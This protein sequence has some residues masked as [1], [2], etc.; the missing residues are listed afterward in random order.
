M[1]SDV[2]RPPQIGTQTPSIDHVEATV[3]NQN[4][5]DLD[6]LWGLVILQ[7]ARQ[8]PG[9]GQGTS[10][11]AM[12]QMVLAIGAPI[13]KFEAIGLKGFEIRHRADF[14]PAV[15]GRGKHLKIKGQ[16]RGEAQIAPTES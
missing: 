2:A 5:R 13:T 16:G 11:E 15:L 12:G 1:A 14:Q 6:S 10:I 9:K 8:Y 4:L 7:N 3:G